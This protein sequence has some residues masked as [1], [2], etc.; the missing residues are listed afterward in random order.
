MGGHER[1]G[2]Q[3]QKWGCNVRSLATLFAVSLAVTTALDAACFRTDPGSQREGLAASTTQTNRA[4]YEAWRVYASINSG[5]PSHPRWRDWGTKCQAFQLH[6]PARNPAEKLVEALNPPVQLELAGTADVNSPAGSMAEVLYNEVALSN[7]RNNH[8]G[9]PQVLRTA[10]HNGRASIPPFAAGSII[11][12]TMWYP[13]TFGDLNPTLLLWF[14]TS[15]GPQTITIDR[16]EMVCAQSSVAK[17]SVSCFGNI[18]VDDALAAASAALVRQGVSFYTLRKGDVLMLKGM[19]IM[20]KSPDLGWVFATFWWD[21]AA[22]ANQ[23]D[24]PALP[25]GPW[26]NYVMAA[27]VDPYTTIYNPNLEGLMGNGKG[28]NSNCLSCHQRA[29][30]PQK[31][32]ECCWLKKG[33][34]PASDSSRRLKTDYVWSVADNAAG[35]SR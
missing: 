1:S 7:I 33:P 2:F 12:K 15:T 17:P 16:S 11:I 13:I 30:V 14:P 23:S 4:R 26:G 32:G 3:G 6:C 18:P 25:S 9:I 28:R 20:F 8:L 5:S 31:P 19:H 24:R 29:V 10:L 21:R 22:A 35:S 34:A 27:T